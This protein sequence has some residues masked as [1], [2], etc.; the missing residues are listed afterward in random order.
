VALV[1]LG[2][3]CGNEWHVANESQGHDAWLARTKDD[4]TSE[5]V[6]V[7]R[8]DGFELPKYFVRF[9]YFDGRMDRKSETAQKSGDSGFESR[10]GLRK[11]LLAQW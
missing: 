9:L 1:L 7:R 5:S 10:A 3:G 6:V 4:A 8:K 11:V 2:S